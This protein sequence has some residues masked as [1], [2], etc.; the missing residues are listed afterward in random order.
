MKSGKATTVGDQWR[1]RRASI[2]CQAVLSLFVTALCALWVPAASAQGVTV[3]SPENPVDCAGVQFGPN[4]FDKNRKCCLPSQMVCGKCFYVMQACE[5]VFGCD[6]SATPDR[7]GTCCFANQ[8]T[9]NKCNYSMV[10]CEPSHGCDTSVR[11][12]GCG[13]GGG[14]SCYGCDNV[15][16][17]GKR[18]VCGV[19]GGSDPCGNCSGCCQATMPGLTCI[20]FGGWTTTSGHRYSPESANAREFYSSTGNTV[21][22][23]NRDV[24]YCEAGGTLC[25]SMRCIGANGI[26]ITFDAAWNIVNKQQL[27]DNGCWGGIASVGC[28]D[29]SATILLEGGKTAAASEVKVGDRLLNPLTGRAAAVKRVIVGREPLPMVEAGFDGYLLR[30]TQEH[31]V[32]TNK[33][34]RRASS[35][36]AGDVIIDADGNERALE[37]VRLAEIAIGQR[38]FNFELDVD[39]ADPLARLIVADNITSGDHVVQEGVL[40]GDEE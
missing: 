2:F 13:C 11:N 38:V 33:G 19:C 17:S 16:N 8:K 34:M 22:W 1:E 31:P 9:C 36:V 25:G 27:V 37:Y 3:Q 35:L 40:P 6:T 14:T 26:G 4:R 7:N 18:L 30:V 5:S 15:P 29:P 21:N 24:H 10:G 28:F 32:L 23:V 12:E 39:S 20:N